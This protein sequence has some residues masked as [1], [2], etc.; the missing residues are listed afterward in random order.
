MEKSYLE[1]IKETADYIRKE[2]GTLP[3]IGVILG[4]GLGD[5]VNHIEKP[6]SLRGNADRVRYNSFL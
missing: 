1:K 5:L 2:V 6:L 3:K 4:T